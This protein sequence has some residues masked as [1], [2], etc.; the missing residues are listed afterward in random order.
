MTE[1]QNTIWMMGLSKLKEIILIELERRFDQV[2]LSIR[3]YRHYTKSPLQECILSKRAGFGR[4][5]I[6]ITRHDK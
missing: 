4:C 1:Y 5:H 3:F 2:D 6:S